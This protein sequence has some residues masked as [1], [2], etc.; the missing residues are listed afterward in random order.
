MT[1]NNKNTNHLSY[2][3]KGQINLWVAIVGMAG[4][5]G[6]SMIT[7]WATSNNR[8]GATEK[9]IAII[10]EREENHYGELTKAIERLDL[11]LDLLLD[12]KA[13]LKK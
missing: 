4:V 10:R 12:N 1:E 7:S 3:M 8:I 5:I 6:A 2:K 11:K 9:D 13:M